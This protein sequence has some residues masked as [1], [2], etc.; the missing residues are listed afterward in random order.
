MKTPFWMCGALLF[1]TSIGVGAKPAPKAT[2]LQE[3]TFD[4]SAYGEPWLPLTVLARH[5]RQSAK[6]SPRRLTV[7]WGYA[8]PHN[9]DEGKAIYDRKHQILWVQYS[10][11]WWE[12][13]EEQTIKKQ[14][15]SIQRWRFSRVTPA[16]I[17]RLVAKYRGQNPD[18]ESAAAYFSLLVEVGC[19]RRVLL[20]RQNSWREKRANDSASYTKIP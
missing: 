13:N 9:G 19:R 2:S 11:F 15:T 20:N 12:E 8:G 7:K 6:K 18:K 1:V 4:A 17:Q 5:T 10:S 16:R 3:A 14:H